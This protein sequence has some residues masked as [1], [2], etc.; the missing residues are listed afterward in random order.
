MAKIFHFFHQISHIFKYFP[1]DNSYRHKPLILLRFIDIMRRC[2]RGVKGK[3]EE[4]AFST[5]SELLDLQYV[6]YQ[7]VQFAK[8][9]LIL[10]AFFTSIC[11]IHGGYEKA[12]S[13]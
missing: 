2:Y 6:M 12:N 5:H 4:F 10:L 8:K 3:N 9:V 11:Y 1:L 7:Y 13:Q